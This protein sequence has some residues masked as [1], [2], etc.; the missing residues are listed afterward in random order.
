MSRDLDTLSLKFLPIA[1]VLLRKANEIEPMIIAYTRRSQAEQ[2][3]MILAGTSKVDHSLHQD[4]LAIDIVPLRLTKKKNWAPDDPV[5]WKLG[6]L[7]KSLGLRWGGQWGRPFPPAIGKV[8]GYFFD[9]GHF[10]MT[11][12]TPILTG[13]S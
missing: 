8:P 6:D 7:G 5:W 1:K 13:K 4:G 11:K 3:A 9:P 2:D 12:T 10:E